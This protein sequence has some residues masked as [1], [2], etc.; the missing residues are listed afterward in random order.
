MNQVAQ[1]EIKFRPHK[2]KGT[3]EKQC[4]HLPF[5]PDYE[6]IVDSEF[7]TL[8]DDYDNVDEIEGLLEELIT[9]SGYIPPII[10]SKKTRCILDHHRVYNLCLKNNLPYMVVELELPDREAE[11]NWIIRNQ[12]LRR[13]LSSFAKGKLVIELLNKDDDMKGAA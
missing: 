13:N 10:V 7:S 6:P 11:L 3:T 1:S 12:C 8:F 4:N 2:G 9:E 5:P